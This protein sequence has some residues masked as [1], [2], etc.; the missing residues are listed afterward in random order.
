MSRCLFLYQ[1]PAK[2]IFVNYKPQTKAKKN[3]KVTRTKLYTT[4]D[5]LE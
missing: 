5:L 3:E 2:E 4:E 1:H